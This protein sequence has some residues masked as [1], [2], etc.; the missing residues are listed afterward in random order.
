L[1]GH[2]VVT[3][4]IGQE[5]L[6]SFLHRMPAEPA[7]IVA[8]QIGEPEL[9]NLLMKLVYSGH[10]ESIRQIV[11]AIKLP[12]HIVLDLVQVAVERQLLR[13][14]GTQLPN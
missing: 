14:L 13:A 11:A 10:L 1:G 7:D 4:A 5:V 12:N 9:L 2:L 6:D 3:G 8:I